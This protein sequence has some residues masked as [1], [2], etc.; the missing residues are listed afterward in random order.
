M[1]ILCLFTYILLTANLENTGADLIQ[2]EKIT[3]KNKSEIVSN[4][5]DKNLDT[6]DIELIK[7]LDLFSDME[8][9]E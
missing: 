4:K 2:K 6:V 3:E 1:K 8:I 9:Y 7:N 5:L